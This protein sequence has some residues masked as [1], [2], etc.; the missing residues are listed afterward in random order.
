MYILQTRASMFLAAAHNMVLILCIMR[1][2]YVLE[3]VDLLYVP[4][5]QSRPSSSR[6]ILNGQHPLKAKNCLRL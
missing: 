4:S 6:A 2:Q 3:V 1:D 5:S